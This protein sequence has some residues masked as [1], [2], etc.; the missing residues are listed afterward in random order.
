MTD[1]VNIEVE[2]E[3]LTEF[4]QPEDLEMNSTSSEELKPLRRLVVTNVARQS[5]LPTLGFGFFFIMLGMLFLFVQFG[6]WS[7]DSIISVALIGNG[8]VFIF[9][10]R[11]ETCIFDEKKGKLEVRKLTWRGVS[12]TEYWLLHIKDVSMEEYKDPQVCIIKNTFKI[13][14]IMV[15]FLFI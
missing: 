9:I 14:L 2:M 12:S 11:K 5:W 1:E 7:V 6:T 15:I 4:P 3:D 8:L 13:T 10:S